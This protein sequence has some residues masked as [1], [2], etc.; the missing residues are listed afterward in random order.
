VLFKNKPG[1]GK[2]LMGRTHQQKLLGGEIRIDIKKTNQLDEYKIL[3]IFR[4]VHIMAKK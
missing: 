4:R 2:L 3:M 1:N